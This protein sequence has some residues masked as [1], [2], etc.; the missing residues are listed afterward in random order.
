MPDPKRPLPYP[1]INL[2]EVRAYANRRADATSVRQLAR[3]IGMRHTSLEKFLA[4]SQPYAKTRVPIVQ[5]Y[6]RV[7]KAG[8]ATPDR[9]VESTV[10]DPDRHLDA[11][12]TD[13]RGE[14]RTEARLRIVGALAQAYRRM[15]MPE[16]EWLYGGSLSAVPE[17]DGTRRVPSAVTTN[18]TGERTG[19]P[20]G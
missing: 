6:L 9:Q 14:V 10:L 11:L 20:C 3:D 15:G 7:T 13:L 8:S 17:Q 19:Q 5:W 18:L 2:D 16:P 1:E 4:G 12:L